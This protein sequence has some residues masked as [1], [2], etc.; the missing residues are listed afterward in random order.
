[1]ERFLAR[2]GDGGSEEI[3]LETVEGKKRI[4]R[5]ESFAHLRRNLQSRNGNLDWCRLER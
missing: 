5:E 1:M 3:A 2:R 4:G